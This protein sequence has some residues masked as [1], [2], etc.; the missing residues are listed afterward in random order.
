[1]LSLM[2]AWFGLSVRVIPEFFVFCSSC[3]WSISVV[4]SWG[5]SYFNARIKCVICGYAA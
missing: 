2:V 1:M 5:M 3:D 4:P